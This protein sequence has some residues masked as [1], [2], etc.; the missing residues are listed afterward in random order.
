MA[1]D[2][3]FPF[4]GRPKP[5]L[6]SYT[7]QVCGDTFLLTM[8]ARARVERIERGRPTEPARVHATKNPTIH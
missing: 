4:E 7:C 3:P 5:D 8:R 1:E 6:V 2:S